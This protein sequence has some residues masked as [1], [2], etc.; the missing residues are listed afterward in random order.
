MKRE[1]E[2]S[3]VIG[4]KSVPFVGI[5]A[6]SVQ[7]WRVGH[8][9]VEDVRVLMSAL[10]AG[11]TIQYRVRDNEPSNVDITVVEIPNKT[12]RFRVY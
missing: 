8:G 12:V 4:E 9:V 7:G 1:I 5:L 2:G 3:F 11:Q 6:D 10:G